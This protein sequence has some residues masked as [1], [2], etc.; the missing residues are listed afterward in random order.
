[1]LKKPLND[2]GHSHQRFRVLGGRYPA[3]FARYGFKPHKRRQ[4]GTEKPAENEKAV[5]LEPS[6]P[7]YHL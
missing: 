5:L 4:R 6:E 3:Q 1:M 7:Q 2:L